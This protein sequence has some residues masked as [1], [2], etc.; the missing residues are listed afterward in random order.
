MEAKS[1]KAIG[2][3]DIILDIVWPNKLSI[4]CTV[5]SYACVYFIREKTTP[6]WWTYYKYI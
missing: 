5:F 3:K 6:V 1:L 2:S 4:Y